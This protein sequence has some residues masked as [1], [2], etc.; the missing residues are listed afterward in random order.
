MYVLP[1]FRHDFQKGLKPPNQIENG[2]IMMV[3]ENTAK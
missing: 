1:E 2:I 3:T